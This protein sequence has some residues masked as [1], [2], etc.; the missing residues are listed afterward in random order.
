MQDILLFF[1]VYTIFYSI[2]NE[3]DVG[4]LFDIDTI[5]YQIVA[6]PLMCIRYS[7]IYHHYK[8]VLHIFH[9]RHIHHLSQVDKTSLLCI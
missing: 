1:V 9:I 7:S 3:L 2:V 5:I 4:I 8:L 6:V